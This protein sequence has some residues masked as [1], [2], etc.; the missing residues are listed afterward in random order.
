[1][2]FCPFILIIFFLNFNNLSWAQEEKTEDKDDMEDFF[3][4]DEESIDDS[5]DEFFDLQ[6]DDEVVEDDLFGSGSITISEKTKEKVKSVKSYNT[7]YHRPGNTVLKVGAYY[8]DSP[9]SLSIPMSL[10][11]STTLMRNLDLGLR[12]VVFSFREYEFMDSV[13]TST[14]WD[15]SKPKLTHLMYSGQISYHLGEA[16]D[17]GIPKFNIDKFDPYVFFGLGSNIIMGEVENPD[18]HKTYSSAMRMNYG[19]GL[20]Y[21]HNPSLSFFIEGGVSDYGQVHFGLDLK[22]SDFRF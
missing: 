3:N 7:F 13:Q 5:D 21:M 14:A 12:I 16:I 6:E 9:R 15:L 2:R 10:G 17:L 20:R 19:G 18:L 1:M 22:I 11:F 8:H 4:F